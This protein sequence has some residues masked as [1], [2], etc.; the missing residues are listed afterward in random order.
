MLK[1]LGM[2]PAAVLAPDALGLSSL[3]PTGGASDFFFE[4]HKIVGAPTEM[5]EKDLTKGLAKQ[6]VSNSFKEALKGKPLDPALEHALK[7]QNSYVG[8]LDPDLAVSRSLSLAT[9][10]RLQRDRNLRRAMEE[11]AN[12]YDNWLLKQ[13]YKKITGTQF[14]WS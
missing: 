9:K 4:S 13:A 2:A 1:M 3:A 6:F 11:S 8:H 5:A 12:E 7:D 14:D 10:I